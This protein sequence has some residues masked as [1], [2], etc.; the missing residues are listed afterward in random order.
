[1]ASLFVAI[2]HNIAIH[3]RRHQNAVIVAIKYVRPS[4]GSV[5]P[6]SLGLRA[7]ANVRPQ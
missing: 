7:Q 6:P 4:D 3:L 1:L 5:R 2:M